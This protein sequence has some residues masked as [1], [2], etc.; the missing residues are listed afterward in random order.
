MIPWSE[1][2]PHSRI[3]DNLDGGPALPH[4]KQSSRSSR[5]LP[6]SLFRS[7]SNVSRAAIPVSSQCQDYEQGAHNAGSRTWR[8]PYFR[9]PDVVDLAQRSLACKFD[10]FAEL[11]LVSPLHFL[12]ST[13]RHS[14]QSV[15]G[16]SSGVE[17]ISAASR[18][19][20]TWT[21]VSPTRTQPFW[22]ESPQ[23]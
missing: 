6:C 2:R 22:L 23:V 10:A 20:V 13:E 5:P 3:S 15:S 19:F 11:S 21:R 14:I 7:D 17:G 16:S 18:L 12:D 4:L 8:H 9:Q 1:D